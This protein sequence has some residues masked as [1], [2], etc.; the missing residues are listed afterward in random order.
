MSVAPLPITALSIV[1]ALGV[2]QAATLAALR[3]G[4]GGLARRCFETSTL[5]TWIGVVDAVDGVRL[6]AALSDWDCRNNRLAE[7]ALASDDFAHHVRRTAQR[8][9]A[10][11]VGVFLGTS[12]SGILSTEIAY[13]ERDAVTGALPAWL[14]YEQTHDNA[15]LARYVRAALGLAG[16]AWVIST[17]CSSGAKAYASAARLIALGVIDAAVVGGV[18]SLCLTTLYGFNALELLSP[19]ICRPWDAHRNGLSLGEGASFALLQRDA[20]EPMGWLLGCGESSDG[21]HMSAPHPEG[22]GAALAMRGAL[23]QAGLDAGAI[24]YVNLHGTATPNNDAAE[25]L[26]VCAVFGREVPVSSTKGA[27]GHTLGAAGA[28]ESAVT[29]LALQ[30]GLVPAGLNLRAPDPALHANYQPQPLRRPLRAAANNSFGFG[31]S[32][33]CLVFGAGR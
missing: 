15:S 7:L 18:D 2:G 27:T 23:A 9:G 3:E 25:D 10:A 8:V 28:I 26:A 1:S 32:N 16:P 13:R 30:E 17:A 12:T 19:E 11:R 29:L 33:A 22:A 4:R 14:R 20:P 24:D 5:D 6:P 21:H 31:G